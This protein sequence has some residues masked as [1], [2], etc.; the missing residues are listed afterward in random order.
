[1]I[2]KVFHSIIAWLLI[3]VPGGLGQR[4]RYRYWRTRFSVCGKNVRIDEGVI[5]HNPEKIEIGDNVWIMAYAVITAPSQD[6]DKISE[7]K[8]CD[9]VSG[10][11]LSI[12]N[13]VQVGL[14]SII[15]GVGGVA[16]GDC[17]TL[18]A[19]VA[20]YSATHLPRDPKDS[21]KLVGTNGMVRRRPVFSKQRP[22]KINEGSW[23][24]VGVVVICAD[25]GKDAFIKTGTIVSRDVEDNAECNQK[26]A[27]RHRYGMYL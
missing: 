3:D 25:I 1:M 26:G 10:K 7:N 18:S 27:V 15:N 2:G 14:F 6:Q 11:K 17:V 23:L 16:I 24:G 22:V 20:I 5:F 19:R 8:H 12:G 21:S 9:G 13:E 4:L